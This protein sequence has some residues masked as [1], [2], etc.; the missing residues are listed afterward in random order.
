MTRLC[1]A[2]LI[3]LAAIAAPQP[4]RHAQQPALS[5]AQQEWLESIAAAGWSGTAIVGDVMLNARNA[6][7]FSEH[8]RPVLALS[9][10][11]AK[12]DLSAL[13]SIVQ[14]TVA[15]PGWLGCSFV[16]P[17]VYTIGVAQE[18]H[19]MVMVLRNK[20]GEVLDKEGLWLLEP[21]DTLPSVGGVS[22]EHRSTLRA[23]WGGVS[24]EWT[25]ISREGHDALCG[26]L[27][28]Y[29]A[30]QVH[31]LS[32]LPDSAPLQELAELCHKA[33]PA[34][35]ALCG[36]K[37][38][39]DVELR[40]FIIR[41]MDR[42]GAVNRLVADGQHEFQPGYTSQRLR[43][44]YLRYY[45]KH[46]DA[47]LALGLPGQM[48]MAAIHELHHQYMLYAMP[49]TREAPHWLIEG[50]A[51]LATGRAM[52][53]LGEPYAGA[54]RREMLAELSHVARFGF[55]PSDEDLLSWMHGEDSRPIY[56]VAWRVVREIDREE[57]RLQ[58]L[59]EEVA[60]HYLLSGASRAARRALDGI[61]PSIGELLAS[62]V[63]LEADG[64]K[65]I[66][67]AADFDGEAWRMTSA[68]EGAALAIIQ[69]HV[70]GP[71]AQLK[72]EFRWHHELGEQLDLIV[73][74]AEGNYSRRF[75]KLA[76]LP[77]RIVLFSFAQGAWRTMGVVDFEQPIPRG[78]EEEP[79]WT[80][81]E[82]RFDS[83]TEELRFE[84]SSGHWARFRLNEYYSARRTCFGLGCVDGIGWFRN[85]EVLE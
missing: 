24:F 78:T 61:V 75:M 67:G 39:E 54:H 47:A 21:T 66:F 69:R 76:V 7:V 45:L 14:I 2:T 79:V 23:A 3:C 4:T 56:A 27:Q 48:L 62:S 22:A 26:E 17:G 18:K 31:I 38:A 72:G 81:F 71:G 35:E 55:M 36:R 53:L 74:F 20:V 73:G 37:L 25:F 32:D 30:G 68:H 28:S 84:A 77:S 60:E 15:T 12:P 57:G 64:L 5:T 52:E 42:Y 63:G 58:A 34:N 29:R 40:L 44:S 82:L 6:P 10:S 13:D 41:D 8:L 85:I 65:P 49:S 1:I 70:P 59:I 9:G 33:Q 80:G 43:H 11:E 83:T 16:E 19:S 50:L 51:E 46:D